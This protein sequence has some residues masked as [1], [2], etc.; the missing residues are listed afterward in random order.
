MKLAKRLCLAACLI[1]LCYYPQR[2]DRLYRAIPQA[3]VVGSY[4]RGVA[5]E[6]RKL[7]RHAALSRLLQDAGVDYAG[8][9]DEK[10][11]VFHTLYWLTGRHTV[12]GLDWDWNTGEA[13]SLADLRVYGAS[14]VG[15]KARPMEFLK[16]IR[17][18]PGLGPLQKTPAGSLY[19]E[20]PRSKTMQQ[21]GLV[22]S[23]DLI[24]GV[25]VAVLSDNPDDVQELSHRVRYDY[26]VS[27]LFGAES[28]P[29]R[30]RPRGNHHLWVSERAA[31]RFDPCL[32][33][34]ELDITSLEQERLGIIASG[35]PAGFGSL[36]AW[37]SAWAFGQDAR[38]VGTPL[39]G[40]GP[41]AAIALAPEV[42]QRI[43]QET[44]R[45]LWH[46]RVDLPPLPRGETSGSPWLYLS[47]KPYGGRI[48]GLAIPYLGLRWPWPAD[49]TAAAW[50][51]PFWEELQRDGRSVPVRMRPSST[52]DGQPLLFDAANAGSWGNWSAGDSI[53]ATAGAGFLDVGSH[54][55]SATR[56]SQDSATIPGGHF[57]WLEDALLHH[58]D[59]CGLLWIDLPRTAQELG[60]LLSVYLFGKRTFGTPDA[61][62]QQ[63]ATILDGLNAAAAFR[64]ATAIAWPRDGRLELQIE[65]LTTSGEVGSAACDSSIR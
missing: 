29:W 24:E 11:G 47:G 5:H 37:R 13:A 26:E 42:A 58:P 52:A 43:W 61:S 14:Y 22:L 28:T 2:L 12:F 41:I 32:G 4:H 34:W 3:A 53:F 25:L 44:T 46:Y 17:W 62:D 31:W 55:A 50:F 39:P 15:W 10:S 60:S 9:W 8:K 6:W 51:D 38:P 35:H 49:S 7:T 36:S 20:F 59:A 27:S 48:F 19:L 45:W 30:T 65:L 18:I 1:W 21:A 23:L 16:L 33:E 56:Q 57:R 63:I 54:L 64:T 40:T